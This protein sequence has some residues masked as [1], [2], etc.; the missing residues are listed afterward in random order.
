LGID[1]VE[2]TF[3][4]VLSMASTY[5]NVLQH[6]VIFLKWLIIFYL[7]TIKENNPIGITSDDDINE[8]SNW[9][10]CKSHIILN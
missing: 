6:Q 8:L 4:V 7:K 3:E 1:I 10:V 2:F 5:H 9:R